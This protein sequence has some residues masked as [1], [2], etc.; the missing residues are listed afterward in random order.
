MKDLLIIGFDSEWVHIPET[1]SNHILSYQYAGRTEKGSW[2][3]IF[4]TKGPE[5]DHRLKF[6]DLIGL[7]IEHGRKEKLVPHKWPKSLYAVAHFSRADMAAF[8]D[9]KK[10]KTSFDNVSGTFVTVTE[11]FKDTF[12][13]KSN[14]KHDLNV[15]LIDT[16]L[17]TPGGKDLANLGDL[18]GFEKITLPDRAIEQ[19]DN[20]LAND[21]DLFKAYA[22]RDAEIAALHAWKM[23]EFFRDNFG[24]PT[25]PLTL[26]SL[27]VKHIREIWKSEDIN[28]LDALGQEKHSERDWNK[29]KGHYFT[30]N[31]PV[32]K[33]SVHIFETFATECYHGGRNEA[34]FF[35][36]TELGLW[37]DF[38]LRAAY[39]TAMASIRVPDY[40]SLHVTTDLN[41][42]KIDE[43]G[44]AHVNFKFPKDTLFPCLPV[45]TDNG[46][47]FP[48]EGTSYVASPEILL[49]LDMGANLELKT[50][51]IVPWQSDVRLFQSFS[52]SIKGHRNSHDKGSVEEQTWKEIGNSLYGKL[53]QGLRKKRVFDSRAGDMDNL[54][55]SMVTQPYLAAYTTSLVRAVLGEILHR[56]P[57]DRT[58]VSATTDGFITNASESELDLTGPLCSFYSKLCQLVSDTSDILESKHIA[59]QLLCWKTR[60]QARVEI[61]GQGLKPILAKA[62]IKPPREVTAP[63]QDL[64]EEAG[65]VPWYSKG[66][67]ANWML[68]LFLDRTSETKISSSHLISAR[69]MYMSDSDMVSVDRENRL[70]MEYDWKRELVEPSESTPYGMT[71]NSNHQPYGTHLVAS[72]KPWKSHEE[73]RRVRDIFDKWR[74]DPG[75]NLKTLED[76]KSWIDYLASDEISKKGIRRS[77]GDVSVCLTSAPME[78]INGIA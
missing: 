44:L 40:E 49:A 76:W 10:I 65:D 64:P 54:P 67:E 72:S 68:R 50:G 39:T 7:A 61:T 55:P 77:K 25:P 38:D 48:L 58:A 14:N 56:T 51:I 11:N 13:D 24:S 66:T 57:T 31:E 18:H 16:M 26:G 21:R 60:G 34:Y 74:S 70:N 8:K 73:F 15:N 33:S 6:I 41:D 42:F 28:L 59:V 53:A 47:L 75:G 46:L 17:I 78:Q 29:R 30:K 5:Q 1:N 43:L 22:I 4:Y 36:F 23:A 3:G 71:D 19:M 52:R 69:E 2:S 12:Y 20:L 62:G 37:N 32:N 63:D 27:S 45:R 35:G 9:F